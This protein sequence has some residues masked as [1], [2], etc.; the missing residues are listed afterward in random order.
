[1]T[2]RRERLG[3]ESLAAALVGM[4]GWTSDGRVLERTVELPSFAAAVGLVVAVAAEAER[5]DHHPDVDLRHRRV[6]FGL[7]TWTADGVTPLDLDLARRID[8]LAAG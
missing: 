2:G 6:R 5:L 7:R 8:A 4:P 1:M 3:R